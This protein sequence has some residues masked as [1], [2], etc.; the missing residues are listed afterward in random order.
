MTKSSVIEID[1]KQKIIVYRKEDFQ[2]KKQKKTNKKTNKN[3]ISWWRCMKQ[4]TW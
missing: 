4:M 1:Q 3:L 2:K